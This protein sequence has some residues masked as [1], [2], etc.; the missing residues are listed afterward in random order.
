MALRLVSFSLCRT[1]R[2]CNAGSYE[3]RRT[4]TAWQ[5]EF[6]RRLIVSLVPVLWCET[7]GIFLYFLS[8]TVFLHLYPLS[9][10]FLR[11][12]HIFSICIG[13]GWLSLLSLRFF[14]KHTQPHMARSVLQHY[15]S[16][17]IE[18]KI[19]VQQFLSKDQWIIQ[20]GLKNSPNHVLPQLSIPFFC[21]ACQIFRSSQELH[22][23]TRFCC[24]DGENWPF[25]VRRLFDSTQFEMYLATRAKFESIMNWKSSTS[26]Q[27]NWRTSSSTYQSCGKSKCSS[28]GWTASTF[29]ALN[30]CVIGKIKQAFGFY[31]LLCTRTMVIGII[32]PSLSPASILIN[33]PTVPHR[34]L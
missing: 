23:L 17:K 9:S 20:R 13:A 10:I 30:S 28:K 5:S 34:L 21:G 19:I 2:T 18:E 29:F 14:A 3:C 16:W 12:I 26:S 7:D 1:Q 11:S 4:L 31:V 27:M 25:Q 24:C 6:G 32:F 22:I 15:L 33:I 8:L